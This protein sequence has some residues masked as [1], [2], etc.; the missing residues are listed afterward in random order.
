MSKQSVVFS[1][2]GVNNKG[3]KFQN[4]DGTTVKDLFVADTDDSLIRSIVLVSDDTTDRI[5]T[6]ILND[7]TTDFTIGAISVPAGSGTNGTASPVD[8]LPWDWLPVDARGK[9]F[10][11]IKGGWKLRGKMDAAV[12]S[13]KT[14][15]VVSIGDDY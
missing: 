1:P 15:T 4:A 8:G 5:A 6:L 12:T 10:L 2:T 3:V 7:G 14:V 11:E 9:K 13:A